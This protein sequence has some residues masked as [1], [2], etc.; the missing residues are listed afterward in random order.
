MNIR[1]VLAAVFAAALAVPGVASAQ[2]K[3]PVKAVRLVLPFA[4]GS[5]VDVL[6]RLYA[7]RMTEGWGQQV[8]VDNRTG[9]NGIIGMELIA[10]AAP[11]G[12]TIGMANIATLAVNPSVYPK[13][14]YDSLRDFVPV[15]LTAT[16]GN[17][18]MVHPSFPV[19]SVKDLVALAKKH[20][21]E[22]N[23]ASGGIG[24]A[25]HIPMALLESMTGIKLVHVAYK[26]I[27][28]AFNDVL[29]GQV[30]IAFT[31]LAQTLPYHRN[32]RLRILGTTGTKRTSATLDIPTIAEAGVAG[33]EADSWT[34]VLV[35]KSTP[36]DIV[37]QIHAEV[38]RVSQLADTRERLTAAGF[39]VVGSS[40]E[41]FAALIRNDTAR[42]GKV[43]RDAGIR[44][45]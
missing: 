45:E 17:C 3:Y 11:D 30:P 33:Y 2:Q 18:L 10:R 31:G 9:A 40:P 25:Q 19:K 44:A 26:G 29:A 8:V 21:G 12:Y 39:E 20:P 13:L 6:A 34:G 15:S 14:S 7:Q 1:S 32:G 36:S 28:P 16:I 43:I 24:S 27:T 23:Y 37:A 35:P 41:A 38:V 42:L 22:L 4:A 5:A